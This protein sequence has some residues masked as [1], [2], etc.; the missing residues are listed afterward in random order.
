MESYIHERFFYD[1]TVLKESADESTTA[2]SGYADAYDSSKR[3]TLIGSCSYKKGAEVS[4]YT[5]EIPA[6]A[7]YTHVA[8]ASADSVCYFDKIEITWEN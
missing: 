7:S 6:D 4:E 5:F 3:G 8:F 1:D 2:Y